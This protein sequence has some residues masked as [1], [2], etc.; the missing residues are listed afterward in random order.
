[1]AYPNV[2]AGY[3]LIRIRLL[4]PVG[5]GRAAAL[6]GVKL[7]GT[8]TAAAVANEVGNI[9]SGNIGARVSSLA[10][11]QD[12][13]ATINN[14]GTLTQSTFVIGTAGGG[15]AIPVAP[16]VAVLIK[17]NSGIIGKHNRGRM[18]VPYVQG[19]DFVTENDHLNPTQLSAWQGV[20]N[21]FFTS[22]SPG[23]T[24]SNIVLLHRNAALTP[25][26][27]TS[28]TVEQLVASQRRRLRKAAHR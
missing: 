25:V 2:P 3:G 28:M 27:V 11:V 12:C 14:G 13:Q 19:N 18:Y 5:V 1:M 17:K 7:T 21:T 6:F 8:P 16:N 23:T 26:V 15:G 22:L 9:Y 24:V 4:C 20:V 10:T